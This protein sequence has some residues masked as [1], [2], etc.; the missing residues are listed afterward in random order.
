MWCYNCKN[1][2]PD[3]SKCSPAEEDGGRIED[4]LLNGSGEARDQEDDDTL[5]PEQLCLAPGSHYIYCC[6]KTANSPKIHKLNEQESKEK[7]MQSRR[8]E[9]NQRRRPTN[10]QNR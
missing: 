2:I 5:A 10:Q 9:K 8:N 6:K 7:E 3:C 4:I 1:Y